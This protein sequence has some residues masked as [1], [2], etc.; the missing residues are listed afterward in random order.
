MYQFSHSRS[1]ANLVFEP[2]QIVCLSHNAV[3]LYGEVVQL[4]ESTQI[5][6]VRPLV[7]TQ[8]VEYSLRSLEFQRSAEKLIRDLRGSSDLLLPAKLFRNALDTEVI[9]LLVELNQVDCSDAYQATSRRVINQLIKDVCLT[10]PEAFQ[11]R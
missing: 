8:S 5:C 2:A 1:S 4:V 9:P 3:C 7:L 6:W 11:A 10:Y